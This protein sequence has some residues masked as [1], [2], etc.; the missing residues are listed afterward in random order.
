[1]RSRILL[2]VSLLTVLVQQA[3]TAEYNFNLYYRASGTDP[4]TPGAKA[5]F[6]SQPGA[7][8]G[9]DNEAPL[10]AGPDAA[11]INLAIYK[12]NGSDG[13]NVASGWY[14]TDIRGP[15]E[16]GQAA[17]I[18]SIFLWAGTQALNQD[19]QLYLHELPYLSPGL[20][21][22]LSLVS[23]PN[24]VTYT[25]PREWGPDHDT[26]TLPFYATDNGTTGYKFRAELT[27]PV[28]EPSSLFGIAA[29]LLGL[30]GFVLRRRRG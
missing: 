26:I 18:D 2:V 13:W 24:G 23:I 10:L 19:L 17:V 12:T 9:H 4:Y 3:C 20:T 25:G 7:T 5:L 29:G 11:G 15:L 22:R 16:S 28:P 1:M 27:A 21:Y 6:W 8:D 30:G 14:V